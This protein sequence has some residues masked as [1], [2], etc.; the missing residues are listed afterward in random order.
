MNGSTPIG[1][2]PLSAG[3]A[4][5]PLA[6]AFV[7]NYSLTAIYSGD[8]N[9]LTAS[10]PAYNLAVDDFSIA[11]ATGSSGSATVLGGGTTNYNLT[12]A[13]IAGTA[14]AGPITF[15]LTGAPTGTVVI[16]SPASVA[17]GAGSTPIL[18]TVKP[19]VLPQA[20]NDPGNI[21]PFRA[22]RTAPIAL[23]LL[24]LPF[25]MRRR[26]RFA[27]LFLW[28]AF[29]ISAIGLSGCATDAS[30]GYYGTNP[31]TFNLTVTATS[32]TLSHTTNLT[33]TVQ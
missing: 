2:V 14:L 9:F 30:T 12:L 26:R 8:A 29:C 4:T 13:P 10:S 21:N 7:G 17:T 18:L 1:T 15:T 19:P 3:T 32:G 11:V 28:M 22:T 5:L 31:Q 16:F 33:L 25:I 6:I 23:A 24:A 27:S 20:H